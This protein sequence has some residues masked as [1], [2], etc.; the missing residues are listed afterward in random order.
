MNPEVRT[1]RPRKDKHVSTYPFKE[2]VEK[3]LVRVCD[4]LERLLT[5]SPEEP[6]LLFG[7][8][9]HPLMFVT[10]VVS[11]CGES[12]MEHLAG[13]SKAQS[14][15]IDVI[16]SWFGKIAHGRQYPLLGQH[17]DEWKAIKAQRRE[18]IQ[19]IQAKTPEYITVHLVQIDKEQQNIYKG[20]LVSF[21]GSMPLPTTKDPVEDT[22]L[23]DHHLVLDAHNENNKI[24]IHA[25]IDRNTIPPD[26]YQ[27]IDLE[28]SRLRFTDLQNSDWLESVWLLVLSIYGAMDT[29]LERSQEAIRMIETQL[30]VRS[31]SN[32]SNKTQ[33]GKSVSIAQA[34]PNQRGYVDAP[35]N[36]PRLRKKDPGEGLAIPLNEHTP[37]VRGIWAYALNSLEG[38]V[39]VLVK[40]WREE[41]FESGYH[42]QGASA[43]VACGYVLQ[44]Y[45]ATAHV[46]HLDPHFTAGFRLA[47]FEHELQGDNQLFFPELVTI[48][49]QKTGVVVQQSAG[50]ITLYQGGYLMHTNSITDQSN[51]SKLCAPG[52]ALVQ[53]QQLTSKTFGKNE[54]LLAQ[55]PKNWKLLKAQWQLRQWL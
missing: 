10:E 50:T 54:Q 37:T 20:K 12:V 19:R 45:A 47:R 4:K 14:R 40:Q 34:Q 3:L 18:D 23:L 44:G 39:P 26:V 42:L 36:I 1:L 55:Q 2:T 27:K 46:D 31:S 29:T 7:A 15:V 21:D 52:I 43:F 32:R 13:D 41:L 9:A 5:T 30:K 53:K 28:N 22:D 8:A 11:N 6:M 38:I 49:T 25:V 35:R 33:L 17:L 16:F 48:D 24:D 51:Q